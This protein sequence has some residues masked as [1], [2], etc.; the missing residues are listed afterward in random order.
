ML[1]LFGFLSEAA[2]PGSVPLLTKIGIPAYSGNVMVPFEGNFH[3]F[4]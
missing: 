3:I 1:G 4:G 2:T